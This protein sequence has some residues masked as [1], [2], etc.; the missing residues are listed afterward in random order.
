MSRTPF[1]LG[2]ALVA[3]VVIAAGCG[4]S[5][6]SS[7]ASLP[8]PTSTTP[9]SEASPKPSTAALITCLRSHGVQASLGSAGNTGGKNVISLFGVAVTGINPASPQFQ[10]ALNACRKYLPGGGPPKLT[11]AQQAARATAM[12]RFAACMRSHGVPNFPDPNGSGFFTPGSLAK[13]DPT[14]PA[15]SRAFQSCNSLQPKVGPRL[16]IGGRHAPTRS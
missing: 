5:K 3:T 10:S 1:A 7:V 15:M 11:P 14:S 13:L 9:T 4:G 16:A 8:S 6:P 12:A 2:L